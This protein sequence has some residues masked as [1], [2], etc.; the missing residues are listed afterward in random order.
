MTDVSPAGTQLRAQNSNDA[1][2]GGGGTPSLG[3][4]QL[5]FLCWSALL[6]TA[7]GLTMWMFRHALHRGPYEP[8]SPPPPTPAFC[9]ENLVIEMSRRAN[10]TVD[11]CSNFLDY[12]CYHRAGLAEANHNL[13]VTEVLYPTLQGTIRTPASDVLRTYYLSCLTVFV[14]GQPSAEEAVNAVVDMFLGWGGGARPRMTDL[15]GILEIKYRMSFLFNLQLQLNTKNRTCAAELSRG[16]NLGFF[17]NPRTQTNRA[18]TNHTLSVVH[19]RFGVNV[20]YEDLSLLKE[21]LF[22]AHV[23]TGKTV[24]SKGGFS[25]LGRVFPKAS[26]DKWRLHVDD[27]CSF[28]CSDTMTVTVSD[29]KIIRK[30]TNII[31]SPY[32]SAQ[33]LAF[34]VFGTATTLFHKD[35][36]SGIV[37]GGGSAKWTKFCDTDTGGLFEVWDLV[38]VHRFTNHQRD[39]ALR[40]LYDSISAAVVADATDIFASPEDAKEAQDLISRVKLVL[41]AQLSHWY[42]AFLPTLT[43]DYC[44]NVIAIRDFRSKTLLQAEARGFADVSW[45]REMGLDAYALLVDEA[46]VVPPI[47]YADIGA[48]ARRETYITGAL[49][50]VELASVL[51]YALFAHQGW[52]KAVSHKLQRHGRCLEGPV[53]D[54]DPTELTYSLLSLRSTVR[55][56]SGAGWHRPVRMWSLWVMSPSQLFYM[57]F[58]LRYVC[59]RAEKLKRL[60]RSTNFMRRI[61]DFSA[62]FRCPPLPLGKAAGCVHDLRI[63][64]AAA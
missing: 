6:A 20:T 44:A 13:F 25:T 10:R 62:A 8:S 43:E 48:E 16:H 18:V 57:L 22:R 27:V 49:V 5:D 54:E 55:A 29:A 33:S 51:W 63:T 34:L 14:K 9:C 53:F 17:W 56:V 37:A 2:H 12:A 32:F 21:S 26:L 24:S 3:Y 38:S 58:Y 52:S 47:L 46:V 35:F 36:L 30:V 59:F 64:P 40:S 60:S 61:P 31:E 15:A 45:T 7:V 42:Q 11:A 4:V 39:N 41:P 23:A 19:E 28:R 1:P 50:G